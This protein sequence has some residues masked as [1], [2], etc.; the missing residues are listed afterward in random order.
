MAQ[1]KENITLKN[2]ILNIKMKVKFYSQYKKMSK[3]EL[4]LLIFV[5][6]NF[7]PLFPD[8]TR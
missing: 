5:I 4:I 7:T 2:S 1:P 6:G 8:K 3:L